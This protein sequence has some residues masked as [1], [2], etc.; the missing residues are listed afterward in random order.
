MGVFQDMCLFRPDY[1]QNIAFGLYL[2]QESAQEV[3][4]NILLDCW[5][6]RV[7]IRISFAI[8]WSNSALP[9]RGDWP[10]KLLLHGRNLSGLDATKR[11]SW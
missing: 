10:K 7:S 9:S 3:L 11:K 6:K 5:F 8:G 4:L 2:G 1:R